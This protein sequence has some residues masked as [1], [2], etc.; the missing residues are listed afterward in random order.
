MSKGLQ[1]A[2]NIVPTGWQH[3]ISLF[4]Q[5]NNEDEVNRL[6]AALLTHEERS[7]IGHRVE[8]ISSLLD[9]RES[10]R[11]LAARLQ[12][13]IATV[14]RG[15]NMLKNLSEQDRFFLKKILVPELDLT[16]TRESVGDG[17]L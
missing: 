4:L 13:G 9:D 10:Q 8:I 17:R 2:D 14:T 1:N 7:A 16:K 11:E 12:I 5:I 15:S 6:F 3:F